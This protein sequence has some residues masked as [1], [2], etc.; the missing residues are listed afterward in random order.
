MADSFK[1]MAQTRQVSCPPDIHNSFYN[2]ANFNNFLTTA[3]QKSVWRSHR[4]DVTAD[5]TVGGLDEVAAARRGRFRVTSSSSGPPETTL[6][7][8]RLVPQSGNYGPTS[9]MLQ[10]GRFAVIPEEPQGSPAQGTSA[11]AETDRNRSPSPEWDFDIERLNTKQDK[12]PPRASVHFFLHLNRKRLQSPTIT[13][14][15]KTDSPFPCWSHVNAFYTQHT[16]Y[17]GMN[18]T[19]LKAACYLR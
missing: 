9:P 1:N 17:V 18:Q 11:Q 10:R 12:D 7:R 15:E 16:A 14:L 3:S 5:G 6:G 8:F 2:H 13:S 19:L 4:N